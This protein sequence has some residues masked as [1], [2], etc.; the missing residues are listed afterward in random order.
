MFRIPDPSL[1][2]SGLSSDKRR[3]YLELVLSKFP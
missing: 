2:Y 1:P 3:F